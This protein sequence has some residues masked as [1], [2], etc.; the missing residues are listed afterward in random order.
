MSGSAEATPRSPKRPSLLLLLIPAVIGLLTLLR[1]EWWRDEAYT[2]LV[3]RAS[4][5]PSELTLNLGFNGH[6][7]PYYFLAW[8]LN[9]I[10]D[11]PLALALPN[12]ALALAA[13]GLFL[14]FAPVSPLQGFLFSLG[15]YPL[16]QY[17]VVVRCYSLVLFL[18][19]LYC[20]LRAA[21]PTRSAARLLVLAALAQVHLLSMAAA[22]VLLALEVLEA[23]RARR[24]WDFGAWAGA[25][26]AATSLALAAWQVSP[27]GAPLASA[28]LSFRAS[29][30]GL[31]N[32]ILPDYGPLEGTEVH[33][34]VGLALFAVIVALLLHGRRWALLVYLALAGSLLSICSLVYAGHRWHHGFYF[35]YLL[36][37]LWFTGEE[38]LRGTAARGLTFVLALQAAVGAWAVGIDLA[39]PYS[40][41]ALVARYLREEGFEEHPLV[42]MKVSRSPEGFARYEWTF[43]EIQPVLLYRGGT[44]YDPLARTFDAF[45]EHYAAGLYYRIQ[46][47]KQMAASLEDVAARIGAPFVVVVARYPDTD[48][49]GLPPPLK[50]LQDFPPVLDFGE[51]YSLYLHP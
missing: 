50:K 3:V 43:D 19:F 35:V 44:A 45:Y 2:W 25:T 34:V 24:R 8:V 5:S 28:P 17:G 40:D 48:E 39:R 23:R 38:R 21:R 10:S 18:L 41:G 46:H 11:H 12:L 20:H 33:L 13:S 32:G 47:R 37:A 31:A 16:Y 51:R 4:G 36:A 1:H 22:A 6:P 30:R 42:G 26:A 29:L 14:R 27:R 7:R 15:F 9:R 49:V